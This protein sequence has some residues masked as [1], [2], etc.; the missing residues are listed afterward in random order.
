[1][2]IEEIGVSYG[3]GNDSPFF[4]E[5][6]GFTRG[7][8]LICIGMGCLISIRIPGP[9]RSQ[10]MIR[11]VDRRRSHKNLLVVDV[12]EC[13]VIPRFIR[14]VACRSG[15][16]FSQKRIEKELSGKI[17]IMPLLWNQGATFCGAWS[18]SS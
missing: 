8:P 5:E 14:V 9:G 7:A 17:D 2:P 4:V 1:M 16:E 13:D 11:G 3:T 12:G 10:S 6:H 18:T 15:Q